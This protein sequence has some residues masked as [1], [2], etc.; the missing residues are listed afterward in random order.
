MEEMEEKGGAGALSKAVSA[1]GYPFCGRVGFIKWDP[2]A[3]ASDVGVRV[4][5]AMCLVATAAE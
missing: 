1:A 5:L 2:L 3:F 4:S